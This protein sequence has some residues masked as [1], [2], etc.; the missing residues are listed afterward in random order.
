[1]CLRHRGM[2]SIL[3]RRSTSPAVSMPEQGF[4]LK[5]LVVL[6]A[7]GAGLVGMVVAGGPASAHATFVSPATA[8]VGTEVSLTLDVPHERAEDVFNT[9]VRIKVP[10]GWSGIS[11]DPF[12]TWTCTAG[13]GE[14]DFMKDSGAEPAQDETFLFA[15]RANDAGQVA[16]PVVQIY[17]TGENVLW[18]ATAI[19]TAERGDPPVTEVPVVPTTRGDESSTAGTP[20]SSAAADED[21]VVAGS[22]GGSDSGPN[23]TLSSDST[24]SPADVRAL[25]ATVVGEDE[26][27]QSSGEGSSSGLMIV[28]VAAA[29]LIA[30]GAAT[31]VVIRRRS[32]S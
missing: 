20:T 14:I 4:Q 24:A 23:S 26:T 7:F 17:S 29:A 30:A 5:V 9:V 2:I 6:A 10:D 1:M 27:T 31:F 15:A 8:A 28:V 18:Q 25:D 21:P 19:V 11:C 12:P 32:G 3:T 16:F 22:A 13:P